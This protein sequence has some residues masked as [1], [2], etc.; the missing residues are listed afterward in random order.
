MVSSAAL[1]LVLVVD[2]GIDFMPPFEKN[3][4]LHLNSER[5]ISSKYSGFWASGKDQD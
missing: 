5:M 2:V 1:V 3:F 4:T